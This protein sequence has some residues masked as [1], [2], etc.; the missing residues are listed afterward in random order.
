MIKIEINKKKYKGIYRW[1]EMALGRFCELASI[2]MPEGYE[3]FILADNKF[4]VDNI[5][6]YIEAVAQVTDKQIKEDFPE[7]YKKV[8]KCLTNIPLRVINK[9]EP[10]KINMLYD[11]YFKPFVLTLL[12]HTP[13]IH[14]MG[15][16]VNYEPPMIKKIRIG[17]R[18]FRLPETV[19]ILGQQIPLANEPIIT[20]TEAADI[21]RGMMITKEDVHRLALFMAIYCRHKKEQYKEER[22]LSREQ[23]FMKA[24]MSAVWAVFFY[25]LRRLPGSVTAIR[26]FGSLPKSAQEIVSAA[27]GYKNMAVEA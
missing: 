16:V 4:T 3:A 25:T 12:Y 11:F 26:L 14:F 6:Q 10:D 15:E 13:V 18:T 8:I 24:P 22:A 27:R 9:L 17:L 5:D 21:Y 23:L 20:Y 7:Y 2:P 19:N 1:D